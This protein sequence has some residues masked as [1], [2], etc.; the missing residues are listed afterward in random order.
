[1]GGLQMEGLQIL[2]RAQRGQGGHDLI[3]FVSKP[4]GVA[5]VQVH[6]QPNNIEM[7]RSNDL[8]G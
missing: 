7:G 4:Q 8:L 3:D 5:Q 6:G 2:A 1:M